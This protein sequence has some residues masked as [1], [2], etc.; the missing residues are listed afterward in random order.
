MVIAIL[1]KGNNYMSTQWITPSEDQGY[2][3]PYLLAALNYGYESRIHVYADSVKNATGVFV[4]S[5][6]VQS[7]FATSVPTQLEWSNFKA[8]LSGTSYAPPETASAVL[9]PS[10]SQTNQVKFLDNTE[11]SLLRLVMFD[12][13][14]NED[15]GLVCCTN[16][17]ILNSLSIKNGPIEVYF[18]MVAIAPTHYYKTPADAY[19]V[20]KRFRAYHRFVAP[21]DVSGIDGTIK[22]GHLYQLKN[23]NIYPYVVKGNSYNDESGTT[24]KPVF[25]SSAWLDL[26]L[27][28][29]SL[30]SDIV[31][32]TR[33]FRFIINWGDSDGISFTTDTNLGVIRVG[34]YFGHT[35]CA[36]IVAKTTD[37]SDVVSYSIDNKTSKNDI[38][39][40]GLKLLSN[41]YLSGTAYA[42]DETLIDGDG[43]DSKF[44]E[45]DVVASTQR[46]KSTKSTFKLQL[47]RG[48]SQH[49][50]SVYGTVSKN[51]ER[52]WFDSLVSAGLEN[53]T[54]YRAGDDRYGIRRFPRILIK[55]NL[56]SD[57]VDY[58]LNNIKKSLRDGI[59]MTTGSTATSPVP[60]GPVKM[61]IGNY[62]YRT[63]I[64]ENGVPL[65]DILYREILPY[66]TLVT[67]ST[68][69]VYYST[70]EQPDIAGLRENLN[71]ALGQNTKY[72]LLDTNDVENRVHIDGTNIDTLPRWM[73]HPDSTN[74][75]IAGYVPVIE[76]AY[77]APGTAMEL[78]NNMAFSSTHENL[79]G[80]IFYI[81][82]LVCTTHRMLEGSART[83]P[84]GIEYSFS[85]GI[86][87]NKEYQ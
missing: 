37:A 55:E 8:N 74:G 62:K 56:Y 42:Y 45:F 61:M 6:M 13:T 14:T 26:G 58:D 66:G 73:V 24:I 44:L 83:V 79:V 81:D 82:G 71:S 28:N 54:L 87:R 40:Y 5:Y 67:P 32:K 16:G 76:V 60:V 68:N 75:A 46:G 53:C 72:L 63:A 51:L 39:D 36:T 29:A 80:E 31:G 43:N 69:W 15:S 41:G 85:T 9:I 20:G 21:T 19:Y 78:L 52:K 70:I 2:N 4:P 3:D 65:Y 25:D 48:L 1:N 38:T 35:N 23:T 34:E 50:V 18:K 11:E 33:I 64:D 17:Q 49:Y 84:V 27:Y 22:A 59:V 77:L 86:P 30:G 47:T 12:K 7:P 10:T 57:L